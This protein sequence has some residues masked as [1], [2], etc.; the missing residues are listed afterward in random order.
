VGLLE[1]SKLAQHVYKEG[2]WVVWVEARILEIKSNR[3][4]RK[5][6]VSAH[7][8]RL[9]NPISQPSLDMPPIW[10]PLIIDEVTKSKESP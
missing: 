10:I 9:K 2:H 3:M 8:A 4:H 5:Y 6:K 7:M 1:N